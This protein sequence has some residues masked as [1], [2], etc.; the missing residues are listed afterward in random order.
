MDTLINILNIL[1][2]IIA[3][4][5]VGF[6]LL[7]F[8]N[9]IKREKEHTDRTYDKNINALFLQYDFCNKLDVKKIKDTKKNNQIH[10]LLSAYNVHNKA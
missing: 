4:L 8:K 5:G 9:I 1:S 6:S 7:A 2:V 10:T 3:M